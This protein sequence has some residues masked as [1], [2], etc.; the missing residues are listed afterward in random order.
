[1]KRVSEKWRVVAVLVG[2]GLVVASTGPVLAQPDDDLGALNDEIADLSAMFPAFTPFPW[3]EPD[4]TAFVY[5]DTKA[6]AE[7][8]IRLLT[9]GELA[10]ALG[11]QNRR[12]AEAHFAIEKMV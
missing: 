3:E 2:S 7:K 9:D 10:G 11:R 5:G 6:F 4:E 8:V 1:M 12:R